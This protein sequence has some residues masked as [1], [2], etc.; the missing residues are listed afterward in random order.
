MLLSWINQSVW[1]VVCT[2][3]P[4]VNDVLAEQVIVAEHHRGAQSGKVLLHPHHLL[5]QHLLAGNLLLDSG[6]GER[7]K[8]IWLI[9]GLYFLWS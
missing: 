6:W 3:F 9:L 2:L 4:V 7:E 1:Y 5:L 8:D